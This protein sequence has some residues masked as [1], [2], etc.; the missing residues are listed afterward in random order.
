MPR[1]RLFGDHFI[2]IPVEDIA[3]MELQDGGKRCAYQGPVKRPLE[4]V[5]Q[6]RSAP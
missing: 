1:G 2:R 3:R 5:L 4:V 6:E